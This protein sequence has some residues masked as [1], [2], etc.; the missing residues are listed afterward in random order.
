MESAAK[1]HSVALI[2]ASAYGNTAT[3]AQA[4]AKHHQA[5]VAVNRLT[6]IH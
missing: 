5:G 3:L 4:L 2:Y 1:K 6:A